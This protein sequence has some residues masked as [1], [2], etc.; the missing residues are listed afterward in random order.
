MEAVV[1][2][3]DVVPGTTLMEP[4]CISATDSEQLIAALAARGFTNSDARAKNRID[5]KVGIVRPKE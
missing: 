4:N 5:S 1:V 2:V 3:V